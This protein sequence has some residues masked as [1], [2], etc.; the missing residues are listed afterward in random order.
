MQGMNIH[1]VSASV[2]LQLAICAFRLL[3]E[4]LTICFTLEVKIAP[5]LWQI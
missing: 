5:D 2:L 1:Y 4:G 3:A